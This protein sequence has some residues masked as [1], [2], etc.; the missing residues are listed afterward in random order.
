MTI[1]WESSFLS[2]VEKQCFLPGLEFE[3]SLPWLWIRMVGL[4]ARSGCGNYYFNTFI[5]T[6]FLH[7]LHIL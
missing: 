7:T 6:I 4:F 1:W 5:T 2:V 3:H